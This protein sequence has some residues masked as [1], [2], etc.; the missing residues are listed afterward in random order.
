MVH[1]AQDCSSIQRTLYLINADDIA[2]PTSVV[3]LRDE[4]DSTGYQLNN[5]DI[6]TGKV[7]L[8]SS[9]KQR[10]ATSRL[11]DHHTIGTIHHN[12][13]EKRRTAVQFNET[14]DVAGLP[15]Q[16]NK[17]SPTSPTTQLVVTMTVWAAT[18]IKQYLRRH[19]RRITTHTLMQIC[20]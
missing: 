9:S 19:T 5:D 8:D 3:D 14:F 15:T 10:S 18:P 11:D 12:N 13:D 16:P 6:S 17:W 2:A 1:H 7:K 4:D 20:P